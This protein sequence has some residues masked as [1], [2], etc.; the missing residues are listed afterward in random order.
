MKDQRKNNVERWGATKYIRNKD[1]SNVQYLQVLAHIHKTIEKKNPIYFEI[2]TNKGGSVIHAGGTVYCV[3][4]NF[5]VN[6]N[7][8]NNKKKLFLFQETSDDFF[9]VSAPKFLRNESIDIAFIDGLH[10]ADQVL[11]DF[12]NTEIYAK[13]NTI[14]LFHDVLPRTAETALANRE[15][16]MW[17]G[18]VWKSMK[19]LMD[20]RSDLSFV[21]LNT[22]PS[23]LLIVYYNNGT[24]NFTVKDSLESLKAVKDEDLYEFLSKIEVVETNTFIEKIDEAINNL[25][26]SSL[27]NFKLELF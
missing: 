19:V 17:T 8:I 1:F 13:S 16:V 11:R 2:G 3:D 6:K 23:G 24:S 5:I 12:Y 22:P 15:T 21:I 27:E 9:S 18:D 4:P 26:F 14:F 25:N 7:I 20:N 10:V